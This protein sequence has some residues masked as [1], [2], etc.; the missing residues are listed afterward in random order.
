MGTFI[1]IQPEDWKGVQGP[2]KNTFIRQAEKLFHFGGMLNLN[3]LWIYDKPLSLLDEKY[4]TEDVV[5]WNYNV[6]DQEI[7]EDVGVDKKRGCIF[8]GKVGSGMF[9]HVVTA[10]TILAGH[11]S[12]EPILVYEGFSRIASDIFMTGWINQV[13][14]EHFPR[15]V[16]DGWTAF[17]IN[18]Y[19]NEYERIT[20]PCIWIDFLGEGAPVGT[21]L[22]I[23]TVCTGSKQA[24]VYIHELS[25][26][27]EI[28]C[29][30]TK[31]RSL[32]DDWCAR[33]GHESL[34]RM[35]DSFFHSQDIENSEYPSECRQI[36]ELGLRLRAPATMVELVCECCGL[37]FWQM[38]SIV[39]ENASLFREK[40]RPVPVEPISDLE[41]AKYPFPIFT[42][43]CADDFIHLWSSERYFKLSDEVLW[44][45]LGF[46]KEFKSMLEKPDGISGNLLKRM[47]T[48]LIDADEIYKGVYCFKAFFDETI[49]HLSDRRYQA[50]WKIF[51]NMVHAESNISSVKKGIEDRY[52]GL[53]DVHKSNPVRKKLRC[54]LALCYN[55]DLRKGFLD[56]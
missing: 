13:L 40:E 17:E 43:P 52:H 2:E 39:K 3:N 10:A 54:F 48:A 20:D 19:G 26:A 44:W 51:D 55:K 30:L 32:I 16:L 5:C 31:L 15:L 53:F 56:F 23:I 11:Y 50:L 22:D 1:Y 21:L 38:W 24:D 36:R 28:L 29:Q 7:W 6:I 18:H 4:E 8:S 9:N 37:D 12:E 41:M 49:E 47:I 35:L 34:L 25:G 14:G 42:L 46:R 45:F 33:D 27:N